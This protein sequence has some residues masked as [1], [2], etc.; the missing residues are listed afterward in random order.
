MPVQCDVYPLRQGTE[1]HSASAR[2]GKVLRAAARPVALDKARL[3]R[4]LEKLRSMLPLS[5]LIRGAEE[6]ALPSSGVVHRVMV[7]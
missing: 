3:F 5:P 6:R 7:I 2:S 4:F 1:R